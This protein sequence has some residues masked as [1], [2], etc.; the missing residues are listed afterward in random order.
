MALKDIAIL[1]FPG[2]M[3]T[4]VFGLSDFLLVASHMAAA[5]VDKASRRTARVRLVSVRPGPIVL[6]GGT[7][8]PVPR[9]RTRPDVLVVPGLEVSRFGE[10]SQRLARLQPEIALLRRCHRQG[11]Q[12]ASVCIGS[13]LLAE[14]GA[15][16]GRR[17]STAWAFEHELLARYPQL[18]LQR[19]AVLCEDRGVITAGAMTSV[20]DLGQR[21]AQ[22]IHGDRVA[23]AAARMALMD[24]PR[25][26]QQPY[27]DA[28]LL[29]QSVASFSQQVQRWLKARLDER[30]D[31]GVL[32]DAFRTSSRT[33]LRRYRAEVGMTP[34]QWLQQARVREAQRLLEVSDASIAQILS[35]V[36]YEDLATFNRLFQRLVG[37]TPAR[38]RRRTRAA[39][40]IGQRGAMR[41]KPAS[42]SGR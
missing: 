29:P 37:E 30:Y 24:S 41:K 18:Q 33:L 20:F 4:E 3:A 19:G 39:I 2:C 13:F 5:M 25:A 11:V 9:W 1:V 28:A 15:L 8:L 22:R 35:R 26:S 32:A 14:A 6:A 7:P 36:G 23:R 17:A 27:V 40:G 31:L 21:L 10:W 12:L 42:P 38:F 34:L 16:D